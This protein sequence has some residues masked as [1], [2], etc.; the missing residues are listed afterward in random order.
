MIGNCSRIKF[1][2]RGHSFLPCDMDT[3]IV[4]SGLIYNRIVA[5][6]DNYDKQNDVIK[7]NNA[8]YSYYKEFMLSTLLKHQ[9][10]RGS[11]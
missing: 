10:K 11:T 5:I 9:R 8:T 3:Y 4:K 1:E 7:F 6:L 2:F